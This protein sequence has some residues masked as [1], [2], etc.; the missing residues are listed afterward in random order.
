MK[1]ICTLLFSFVPLLLMSQNWYDKSLKGQKIESYIITNQGDTIKGLLEYEAPYRLAKR[2]SFYH[3]NQ[4]EPQKYRPFD[5]RG[6][7][8]YGK[9]WLSAMIKAPTMY[10]LG[11]VES[12]IPTFLL[13]VIENAPI[14]LYFHYFNGSFMGEEGKTIPAYSYVLLKGKN[15][16]AYS[17][18]DWDWLYNPKILDLVKDSPEIIDGIKSEEYTWDDLITLVKRYNYFKSKEGK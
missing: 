12:R 5:I 13:P 6:F 10:E 16:Y 2:I 14:H 11:A 1:T 15:G 9:L 4:E 8:I 18:G 17:R 7:S 3:N